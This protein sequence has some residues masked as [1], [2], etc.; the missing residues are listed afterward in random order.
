MTLQ[1]STSPDGAAATLNMRLPATANSLAVFR[2][3]LRGW[4]EELMLHP[5]EIFDVVLACSESLTLVIEERPRQVAL[6]VDVNAVHDGEI[7]SVTTR[8]YGLWHESHAEERD[9]PLSLSLMRALM[10]SVELRRH[11]DGQTIRLT[12][13]VRA[14]G[15]ELRAQLI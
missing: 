12:R 6:V 5:A 11:P 4:L 10:D 1:M 15:N 14:L 7:L 2:D 3:G 13:R 8:D 9:E